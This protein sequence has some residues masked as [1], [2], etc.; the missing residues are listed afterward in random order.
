MAICYIRAVS[1]S[2]QRGKTPSAAVYR[3]TF[4]MS[5]E[6]LPSGSWRNSDSELEFLHDPDGSVSLLIK[7]VIL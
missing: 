4:L 5:R 3:I 1:T 7:N 2:A 6:T